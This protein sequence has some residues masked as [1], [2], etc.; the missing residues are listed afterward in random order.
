MG[1]YRCLQVDRKI[2]EII[3][4]KKVISKYCSS[5][6]FLDDVCQQITLIYSWCRSKD[7]VPNGVKAF[8]ND[9]KDKALRRGEDNGDQTRFGAEDLITAI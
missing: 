1:Q 5:R 2:K 7:N 4:E 8:R 3:T 6:K 9:R